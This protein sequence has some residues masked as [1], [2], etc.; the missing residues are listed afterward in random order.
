MNG[1]LPKAFWL[2]LTYL[3]STLAG[4]IAQVA[5][6]ISRTAGTNFLFMTNLNVVSFGVSY[7]SMRWGKRLSGAAMAVPRRLKLST[8]SVDVRASSAAG[9]VGQE[10]TSGRRV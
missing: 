5:F 9:P 8:Q 3:S 10:T 2:R 6:A 1:P 4:T 7:L